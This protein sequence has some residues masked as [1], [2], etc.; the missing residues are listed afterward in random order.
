MH[1]Y[2]NYQVAGD[3]SI[4]SDIAKERAAA[5]FFR[6]TGM[7]AGDAAVR[8][9]VDKASVLAEGEMKDVAI[10]NA[11]GDVISYVRVIKIGGVV[12]PVRSYPAK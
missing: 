2:A 6:L 5:D 3:S 4:Q 1:T 7:A 9:A 11:S 12:V 10:N 8:Q